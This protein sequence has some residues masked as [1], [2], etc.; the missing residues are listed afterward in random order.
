MR[1]ANIPHF[2]LIGKNKDRE[3]YNLY[4]NKRGGPW[5][6]KG[7]IFGTCPVFE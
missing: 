3:N 7:V 5:K 6:K 1:N 4:A 2:F